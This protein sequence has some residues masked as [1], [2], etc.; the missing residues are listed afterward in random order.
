MFSSCGEFGDM[1]VDP[2]QPSS[3]P[4]STLLT[5]AQASISGLVGATLPTLYVQYLSETQYTED[6]RYGTSQFDF[7]G[8]YTGP[9]IN[10]EEIIRLNTDEATA[11][12]ASA[13][14]SNANQIAVARIMKAYYFQMMTDRWGSLPYSDALQGAENFSPSY[15]TQADIYAA[16]INEL[17]EAAAQIDGGSGVNGDIVFGGNMASWAAFANTIRAT[18]ALRMSDVN[19][20]TAQSEFEDAVADGLISSDVTFNHLADANYQNPWFARFITRTDYA[21]S[22]TLIDELISLNDPRLPAFADPA[23]IS[24][25]DFNLTTAN[26]V[27]MPY[28]I[29]NAGD[30]EN[31]SVSFITSDQIYTQS[32]AQSIISMAQVNFMLAEAAVKGWAAGG[33]AQSFYE[34]GIQASLAQWGVLDIGSYVY[35]P[36]SPVEGATMAVLDYSDYIAQAGV[37][38]DAAN[39]MD[40]IATQKW[41]ALYLNGYEAWAEW[42]RMDAPTLSPA[43]DFANNSGE[44]P[45]RHGYPTSESD[46]NSDN[47]EAAV[48]AQG[49]DGLDTRLW[50]DVN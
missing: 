46:L 23:L 12:L 33:T 36:N 21:V 49:A 3:A 25:T 9:L 41:L 43:P 39:A 26:Y 7:N 35:G 15:D 22:E 6:S 44:I 18:M 11:D 10:L 40:Q 28:G 45:V 47:Y 19:A 2:N 50:W 38:Y 48:S 30:I 1:N 29:Q 31:A 34:A 20:S 13:D 5:S 16:V 32:A 8:W 4:T 14:G 24:V 42:R 27:G 37:A 17:K